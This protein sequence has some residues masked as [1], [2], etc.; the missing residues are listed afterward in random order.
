MRV[1]GWQARKV[2]R[3]HK[4]SIIGLVLEAKKEK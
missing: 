1:Q 2:A 3:F 4:P